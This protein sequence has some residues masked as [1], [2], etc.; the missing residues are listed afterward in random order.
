MALVDLS[1]SY[2]EVAAT[3]GLPYL[4]GVNI[5]DYLQYLNSVVTGYWSSQ[6]AP[7]MYAVNSSEI[8]AVNELCGNAATSSV[9]STPVGYVS[10]NIGGVTW[11]AT[12]TGAVGANA[13]GWQFFYGVGQSFIIGY[14]D[15]SDPTAGPADPSNLPSTFSTAY[16]SMVTG[17][18]NPIM[19]SATMIGDAGWISRFFSTYLGI[20]QSMRIYD[21]ALFCNSGWSSG[22]PT[23]T[24]FEPY[25][26]NGDTSALMP[27][28]SYSDLGTSGV[29]Y[30]S[31]YENLAQYMYGWDQCSAFLSSISA[32]CAAVGDNIYG[33]AGLIYFFNQID[34]A[35]VQAASGFVLD[36]TTW[37]NNTL[38][39]GKIFTGPDDIPLLAEWRVQS[40]IAG[41][42]MQWDKE[43]VVTPLSG[44][45]GASGDIW[46]RP[47]L[48]VL[49]YLMQDYTPYDVIRDFLSG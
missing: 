6:S 44:I 28:S 27:I 18:N 35:C 37:N 38:Y 3:T 20:K 16:D 45:A 9:D 13:I 22:S 31:A 47:T 43:H 34:T 2:L 19:S 33:L 26:P 36:Q 14:N 10:E 29:Y 12:I 48:H 25:I 1:T 17:M 39:R 49:Q 30:T 11:K 23:A 42:R 5:Y 4:D 32:G 46:D 7:F 41:L 21:A 15:Y 40:D 8:T 24:P